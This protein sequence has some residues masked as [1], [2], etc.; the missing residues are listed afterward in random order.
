MISRE[1][2]FSQYQLS[3]KRCAIYR[4]MLVVWHRTKWMSAK[5]SWS[6][7]IISISY[8]SFL[9]SGPTKFISMLSKQLLET[10]RGYNSP[11]G[12]DVMLLFYIQSV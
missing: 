2:L 8:L 6:V 4:A 5:P 10:E 12:L 11:T 9:G 3:K 1:S 7:T